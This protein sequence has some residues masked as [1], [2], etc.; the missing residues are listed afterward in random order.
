MKNCDRAAWR[1]RRWKKKRVDRH[2]KILERVCVLSL[3]LF[4][5]LSIRFCFGEIN[6]IV[7]CADVENCGINKG[8]GFIY[9]YIY[10]YIYYTIIN[11]Y[12][13][14]NIVIMVKKLLFY[15]LLKHQQ[16]LIYIWRHF[17]G[18]VFLFT[19]IL[20]CKGAF[21]ALPRRTFAFEIFF[22]F[23]FF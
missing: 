10:I 20:E 1:R 4:L 2:W 21:D 3:C 9:I 18:L 8:F 5:K 6:K 7:W 11:N 16:D 14:Q 19:G 17:E 13:H 22:F 23:F 12:W 15:K